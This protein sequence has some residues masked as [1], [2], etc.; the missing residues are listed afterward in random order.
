MRPRTRRPRTPLTDLNTPEPALKSRTSTAPKSAVIVSNIVPTEAGSLTSHAGGTAR[1]IC[2]ARP[3]IFAPSALEQRNGVSAA[4]EA[5]S[6][7]GTVAWSRPSHD[8]YGFAFL[9]RELLLDQPETGAAAGQ[10]WSERT[11]DI[12]AKPSQYKNSHNPVRRLMQE[13]QC[14]LHRP[15]PCHNFVH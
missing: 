4:R 11:G 5:P 8:G 12:L 9:H 7:R 1:A 15:R 6:Q 14:T 2:S 10:S 13:S 3:A